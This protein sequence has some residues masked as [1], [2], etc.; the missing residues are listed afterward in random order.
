MP[1]V[2]GLQEGMTGQGVQGFASIVTKPFWRG[3]GSRPASTAIASA[4]PTARSPSVTLLRLDPYY[5]ETRPD[6]APLKEFIMLKLIASLATLILITAC[7][8]T[9]TVS[10]R[11]I[12][13][14]PPGTATMG[15][16]PALNTL[17]SIPGAD[18]I[19]LPGP[20]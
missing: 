12:D 6:G 4:M 1:V 15:S 16:S 17:G 8:T 5:L 20:N 19:Y 13:T 7:S 2:Q 3:R 10:S 9:A 18:P 11:N 14:R